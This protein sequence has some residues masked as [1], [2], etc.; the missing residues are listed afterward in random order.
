RVPGTIFGEVPLALGAPFP[1]GYRAVEASRV[2]RVEPSQYY[3]LAASNPEFATKMGALARERLGGLQAIAADPPKA[4]VTV[5]R[6]RRDSRCAELRRFLGRNQ[7][8]YEWL[9]PDDQQ[10]PPQS[11]GPLPNEHEYPT[12]RCTDGT[13]LYRPDTRDVARLVGLQTNPRAAEY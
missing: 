4:R 3:T 1:G 13:V 6:H 5:V 11:S 10:V 7:V 9:T 2:M 8:S 12:I